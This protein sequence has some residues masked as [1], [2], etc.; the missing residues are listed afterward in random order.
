[1]AQR[2]MERNSKKTFEEMETCRGYGD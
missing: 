2:D 1:L